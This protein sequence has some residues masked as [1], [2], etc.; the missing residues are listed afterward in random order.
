MLLDLL[1][2][3][4]HW[5]CWAVATQWTG[6]KRPAPWGMWSSRAAVLPVDCD[7][8]AWQGRAPS[9]PCHALAHCNVLTRD[10]AAAVVTHIIDCPMTFATRSRLAAGRAG[11]DQ[12]WRRVVVVV[13][14]CKYRWGRRIWWSRVKT[15]QEVAVVRHWD[16][17][18]FV[19][20]VVD[21]G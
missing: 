9:H 17:I 3:R 6:V 13:N 5:S 11:D 19:S 18:R 21:L 14:H 2:T 20:W 8:E 16:T 12:W 10:S 15:E 4:R 7:K 1:T